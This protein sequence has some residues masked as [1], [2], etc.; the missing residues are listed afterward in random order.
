MW[1]IFNGKLLESL[2]RAP[3]SGRL[4][5]RVRLIEVW[6]N[7]ETPRKSFSVRPSTIRAN[8]N[9][10]IKDNCEET[11]RLA[12][13]NAPTLQ[14]LVIYFSSV[15]DISSLIQD[16]GGSYV[17]YPCLRTLELR[18][19]TELDTLYSEDVM[20]S[21]TE[22]NISR[23]P[24][25][26]GAILFPRLRRLRVKM[27]YQFG[28]DTLFRG[29]AATLQYVDFQLFPAFID[30][31]SKLKVFTPDR[32]PKLHYVR[33]YQMVN[34]RI[35]NFA[36]AEEYVRFA[37]SV[38]PHAQVRKIDDL[39]YDADFQLFPPL[40]EGFTDI[41]ILSLS[42]T[43]L[44]FWDVVYLIESLPNL[45]YLYTNSPRFGR[46]PRGVTVR[47]LPA[48]VISK[49]APMSERFRCWHFV[50]GYDS[51]PNEMARCVLLLA[52]VCP[53]FDYIKPFYYRYPWLMSH[54]K[55]VAG[56]Q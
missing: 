29:N 31:V 5:P 35:P 25:F 7:S 16:P 1:T 26:V 36:T 51:R 14:F 17:E 55:R 42:N 49:Y 12:R 32:H 27:D 44:E 39:P 48:Y 9:Y 15:K 50:Y 56:L 10:N 2:S 13:Q 28:D 43:C 4:F 30:S 24:V 54:M 47:K 34:Y 38:G 53:N 41:R 46:M 20:F 8:I 18:N 23:F 37:L 3:Y 45:S 40:F 33:T 22:L 21:W 11:L 19:D 52:L 6:F